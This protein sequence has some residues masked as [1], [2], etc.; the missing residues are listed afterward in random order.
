MWGR[1]L[2]VQFLYPQK[3]Y[4]VARRSQAFVPHNR[5]C[6]KVFRHEKVLFRKEVI[7][8]CPT[9]RMFRERLFR[10]ESTEKVL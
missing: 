6:S 3:R 4:S 8:I 9:E 10:S 5:Q 2:A 1:F 7:G